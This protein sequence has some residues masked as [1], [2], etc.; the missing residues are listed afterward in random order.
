MA[1]TFRNWEPYQQF[2][3]PPSLLDLVQPSDP[4]VFI[5]SLVTEHLN[6]KAVMEQYSE[7]RG[8]PPY[9]PMMMISLILYSFAQKMYSSR[10]ID[11]ACQERIG[12]MVVTGME[13]PDF[14]T[15]GRFRQRHEKALKGFFEQVTQLCV[16]AGMVKLGHVAIDGT[17]IRGSAAKDQTV[18]YERMKA[19]TERLT[20]EVEEWFRQSKTVDQQED[21]RFGEDRRG[22]E[23]PEWVADKQKRVEK[24]KQAQE[25]L[26]AEARAKVKAAAQEPSQEGKEEE[27]SAESKAVPDDKDKRNLSDGDSRLM[28]TKDGW[29]QGYNAQIA[30]D[31]D[32]QVIVAQVVTNEVV[33]VRQLIPVLN[34][35]SKVTSD[36]AAE[37]SA[38]SG[39][40]S[41]DNLAELKQE[42]I[43]GFI[44]VGRHKRDGSW[45]G[46]AGPLGQEMRAR[47][48]RGGKA[49]RYSLRK[50]TVETVF[51]IIKGARK[52]RQFQL[53]GLHK[54]ELE[55]SLLCT[56]HN[57]LKLF[58][59]A[60]AF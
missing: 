57:L 30:V 45:A 51:G 15:I 56:A 35:V 37:V 16:K 54:V 10:E 26:E 60:A 9:H 58:S 48:N 14:R 19:D 8:Q 47:I 17:R 41:E 33:D 20:A 25:E 52:F 36:M 27:K 34:A 7:E 29:I 24:L 18:S 12:F 43:R 46:K 22:D 44:A 40:Y 42:G 4:C 55:W 50:Q 49:S 32:S 59:H 31:A 38:D 13:R 6:V 11:R 28:K 5:L 3:F 23:M 21:E 53:R 1:K 39:Y 2:L